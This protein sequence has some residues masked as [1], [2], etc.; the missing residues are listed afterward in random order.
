M[1]TP[2]KTPTNPRSSSTQATYR[3]GVDGTPSTKPPTSRTVNRVVPKPLFDRIH[4]SVKLLAA[5]VRTHRRK[6]APLT[7]SAPLVSARAPPPLERCPRGMEEKHEQGRIRKSDRRG[8]REAWVVPGAGATGRV[9]GAPA[10]AGSCAGES[11]LGVLPPLV[12]Q[13]APLGRMPADVDCRRNLR[14]ASAGRTN[15]G[16]DRGDCPRDAECAGRYCRQVAGRGRRHGRTV[17]TR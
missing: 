5:F 17:A 16:R 2:L 9:T 15:A 14:F 12:R 1:P 6:R 11:C 4:G 10:A 13:A 3:S 8:R 7:L